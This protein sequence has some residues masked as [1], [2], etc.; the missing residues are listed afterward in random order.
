[1]SEKRKSRNSKFYINSVKD[2]SSAEIVKCRFLCK[3]PPFYHF[4]GAPMQWMKISNFPIYSLTNDLLPSSLNNLVFMKLLTVG[5]GAHW[6]FH[7]PYNLLQYPQFT[8][9][10]S[11]PMVSHPK[12]PSYKI[13]SLGLCNK[14]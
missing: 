10:F 6:I 9:C 2:L 14:L 3:L 12:V 7:N 8:K 4:C 11:F 13:L 5:P 1:M